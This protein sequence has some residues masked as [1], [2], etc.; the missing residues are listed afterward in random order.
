MDGD[1]LLLSE[2][3]EGI[4]NKHPDLLKVV[5]INAQSLNND[6]HFTEFTNVFCNSG[7]DVIAVSETFYKEHSKIELPNYKV[8]N[9]NRQKRGGGGVALYVAEH[10][11]AKILHFTKNE[12]FEPEYIF[13][14]VTCEY[15][16]VLFICIYRPPNIF[17]MDLFL[18]DVYKYLPHYKYVILCGD[19]NA[20]FDSGSDENVLVNEALKMCN[21][22]P[23]PFS[24]TFHTHYS[25]S[26]LDVIASN[27]DDKLVAYEQTSAPAFSCHDLIYA[28]YDLR[29]PPCPK[30][31]IAYRDFKNINVENL[32]AD[33]D[34]VSWEKVLL[35]NDV[36]EKVNSFND[37]LTDLMDKHT[38][39]KSLNIKHKVTPW[40][41]KDTLKLNSRRNKARKKHLRC[42]TDANYERFRDLRNKTKQAIRNAKIR[43][44]HTVLSSSSSKAVWNGIRS[45]GIKTKASNDH[46]LEFP[47]NANELN[48]HYVSV[49]SVENSHSVEE[50]INRYTDK[51]QPSHEKFYF[52]YVHPLEI[53]EAIC[54]IKSKAVG[55]DGLPVLF[56]KIILDKILIV[57]EHIFNFCLQNGV[58]PKVWKKANVKPI[59]KCK[60]PV[61]CKDFRP[62]S[63]LCVLAKA[64]EKIVHKQISE[65]IECFKISNP[66]QSGFKKG[67]NTVTALIKVADDL[68]K[69][70]DQRKINLLVL[71]DFSKAFDR[72]HH[73]LLLVK[74]RA[75]GFSDS[76]IQWFKEY[77]SD[78]CQRVLSGENFISDWAFP[79]TG[80]PQGSVLGPL[81]FALYIND[82]SDV[83][84]YCFYDLYA[85]D[86][87]LYI[88][89]DI[90]NFLVAHQ[91]MNADLANVVNYSTG[92]NLALN[93]DKTQPIIIGSNAYVAMLKNSNTPQVSINGINVPYCTSVLNL[94]VTFDC[95]LN[96]NQQCI[97]LISKVFG[98]LA[99]VKRNFEFLPV[100]IRRRVVQTL[101]FPILDYANVLY[102]DMP[103]STLLKLQ[104]A[105]NAC[106][107]FIS[108]VKRSDHI[109]PIYKELNILKIEDRIT[110][111]LATLAWKIRK[112]HVPSYINENYV[113][114]SSVHTR[115]NRHTHNTLLIPLHR[116]EKYAKSFLV[117]TCKLWNELN[118]ESFLGNATVNPLR[119]HVKKALLLKFSQE[120]SSTRHRLTI[121]CQY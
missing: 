106:L 116:T 97:N 17:H 10:L 51:P 19:L 67:H 83:L 52:K 96:W 42:K 6:E 107:R 30:R 40:I 31:V 81:L 41:T 60:K 73:K 38:P 9:A 45:L 4:S 86:F 24:D 76:A 2:Y 84:L 49:S 89:F 33:I 7:M 94:G 50:A 93:I 80:V 100:N 90:H 111:A 103:V 119:L 47:V 53:K 20:Q 74:L 117:K 75:L 43:Y 36:D 18:S 115:Q 79:E 99:Q 108:G 120:S 98:I 110:L 54:S 95:T 15:S 91:Y 105:Q 34:T 61:L 55:E 8:F 32:S 37:I 35:S 13:V 102:T 68:R 39:I 58:F 82:I 114:M 5:H 85:D 16:K 12:G 62:V 66:L 65:Y 101:I 69:S 3:V 26:N 44:Y 118:I 71:L 87:Q 70:V 113:A 104:R 27:I 112:Y 11:N 92:H 23:V 78:R 1:N 28:V 25:S 64:I 46:I 59:P 63:I 48:R 22:V 77:L 121:T 57:I 14:E 29:I 21:L 72:V 56:L 109:T 88:S